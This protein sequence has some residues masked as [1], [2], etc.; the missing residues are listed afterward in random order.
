MGISIGIAIEKYRQRNGKE[1]KSIPSH[2]TVMCVWLIL[3][4]E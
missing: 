3:D 2:S 4:D 1:K